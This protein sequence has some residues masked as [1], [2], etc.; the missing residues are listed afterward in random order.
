[1]MN[2][3]KQIK[4][5]KYQE[6]VRPYEQLEESLREVSDLEIQFKFLILNEISSCEEME[7]IQRKIGNTEG[8]FIL[9]EIINRKRF[10]QEILS[11]KEKLF[12]K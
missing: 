3:K 9:H 2:Q 1:M 4:M 11:K 7:E 8:A 6:G 12:P 10:L 5:K